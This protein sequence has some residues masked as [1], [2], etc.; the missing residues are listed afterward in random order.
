M[1]IGTIF[2]WSVYEHR[3]CFILSLPLLK[4]T[5]LLVCSTLCFLTS[6]CLFGVLEK[7]RLILF[8][9]LLLLTLALF[10]DNF[11]TGS[12][13]AITHSCSVT[14]MKCKELKE[15]VRCLW[16][17]W[18]LFLRQCVRLK[19]V[20]LKMG[21]ETL[22]FVQERIWSGESETYFLSIMSIVSKTVCQV[23]NS[24]T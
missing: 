9:I 11:P 23:K 5:C 24:P 12:W 6:L 16:A 14:P 4:W 20:Q 17:S 10:V 1:L 21:L 19:V 3:L 13:S 8:I 22:A 15:K 2:E 18:V 7:C